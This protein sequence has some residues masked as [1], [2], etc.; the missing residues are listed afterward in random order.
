VLIDPASRKVVRRTRIKGHA[1]GIVLANGALWVSD[2]THGR[3]TRV[4][5][6]TGTLRES[7]ATGSRPRAIVRVGRALWVANQGSGTLV[8][9]P[10][11]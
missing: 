5:R 9:V 8:R 6:S 4:D 7:R 11:P 2:F 10:L 1:A 3:I